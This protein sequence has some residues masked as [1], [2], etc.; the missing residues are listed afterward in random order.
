MHKDF[1]DLLAILN[2]NQV[3]F[4]IVG[5]FALAY[6]GYP[7]NT[8]DIDIWIYPAEENANKTVQAIKE[9][10]GST[11]GVTNEDIIS[12]KIIQ[13]GR[14]PVRI[15]LISILTGVTT[16]E[17]WDN[18]ITGKFAGIDVYF[19]DKKTFIKNKRAIGRGKDIVDVD[20]ISTDE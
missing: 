10:F 15:D 16:D 7:R 9:F 8:G 2:K 3:K 13:F 5:A 11:L 17:I 6:H 4:L 20:A 12:G 1:E 19:I 14:P 18:R